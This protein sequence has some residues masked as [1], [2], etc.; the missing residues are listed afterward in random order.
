VSPRRELSAYDR[1]L[2]L[3]TA[4]PRSRAGL[5]QRLQD[6][7]HAPAE[8]EA[9]LARVTELGYL[10]DGAFARSQAEA[11]LARFSPQA[12]EIKLVGLGLSPEL[13]AEAVAALQA[14]EPALARSI[15]ERRFGKGPLEGK[16][17]VKAAR[18]LLGRGF[19]EDLVEKLVG[20]HE[21]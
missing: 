17:A 10:D 12:V 1:A 9:A 19:D 16:A 15:L 5:A 6:A 11:L 18:F 2:R 7:G 13:A 8:V 20:L 3:L 14:D 21:G 4:R